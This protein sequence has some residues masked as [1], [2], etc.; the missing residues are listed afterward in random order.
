M[1]SPANFIGSFLMNKTVQ[2]HLKKR[3]QKTN[4]T[5]SVEK[6]YLEA[7]LPKRVT[8]ATFVIVM[9]HFCI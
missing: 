9:I 6:G 7:D 3:S 4:V 1:P 8:L 5:V 2:I